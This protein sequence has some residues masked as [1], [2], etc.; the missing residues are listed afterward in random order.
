MDLGQPVLV[1]EEVLAGWEAIQVGF[2]G[3]LDG[4]PE[5]VAEVVGELGS[6][7]CRRAELVQYVLL[8]RVQLRCCRRVVDRF[9]V[10]EYGPAAVGDSAI[11]AV[12]PFVDTGTHGEQI[13]RDI[14]RP[15][16]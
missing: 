15:L 4:G 8:G 14:R 3:R 7:G 13:H 9:H 12:T 1:D 6:F 16:R 5:V 2:N 10:R 11:V